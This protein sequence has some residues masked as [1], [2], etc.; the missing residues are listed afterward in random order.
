[1]NKNLFIKINI[2]RIFYLILNLFKKL[3]IFCIAVRI[4]ECKA[5]GILK[6]KSKLKNQR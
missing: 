2:L 4:T 1:M 5:D 6:I 3:C